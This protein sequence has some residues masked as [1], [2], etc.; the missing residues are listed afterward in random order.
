MKQKTLTFLCDFFPFLPLALQVSRALARSRG[1]PPR[2]W[3]PAGVCGYTAGATYRPRDQVHLVEAACRGEGDA[4]RRVGP[5]P[6]G[7]ARPGGGG[8][9]WGERGRGQPLG[10]VQPGVI[11][12]LHHLASF[13]GLRESRDCVAW[14]CESWTCP[15]LTPFLPSF[16]G[17][18]FLF[19]SVVFFFSSVVFFLSSLV[20]FYLRRFSFFFGGLLFFFRG[21]LSFFGGFLL[22]FGGFL[23]FFGCLAGRLSRLA[24]PRLASPRHATFFQGGDFNPNPNRNPNPV[25]SRLFSEIDFGNM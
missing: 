4:G 7:G 9:G 22:F 2:K 16:S 19:S 13:I 25:H 8:G 18:V 20:F 24:S 3:S 12:F 1:Q 6:R 11:S 23:F 10:R 17:A 5:T 14:D 15:G 21:F